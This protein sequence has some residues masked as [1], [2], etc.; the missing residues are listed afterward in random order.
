MLTGYLIGSLIALLF[1]IEQASY[2][3]K[4]GMNIDD[5]PLGLLFMFTLSWIYV[6]IY[7]IRLKNRE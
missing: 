2:E 5:L 3:N 1:G 6:F 4:K 7:L